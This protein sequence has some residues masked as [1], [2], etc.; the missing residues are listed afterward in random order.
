MQ[1]LKDQV[2]ILDPRQLINIL[3]ELILSLGD[4]LHL[5]WDEF[6]MPMMTL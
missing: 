3:N 6:Y 5:H 4:R 1:P 2:P